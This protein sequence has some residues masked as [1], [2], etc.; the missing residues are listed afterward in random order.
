[1]NAQEILVLTFL[2]P[3]QNGHYGHDYTEDESGTYEKLVERTAL[4]LHVCMYALIQKAR[5]DA[6]LNVHLH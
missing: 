1:M 2:Y 3:W 4:Q 6:P 5:T